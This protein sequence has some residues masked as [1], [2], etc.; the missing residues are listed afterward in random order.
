MAR[1]LSAR[2]MASGRAG[3]SSSPPSRAR[4]GTPA[5]PAGSPSQNSAGFR[6]FRR[7]RR[8]REIRQG[9]RPRLHGAEDR[10]CWTASKPSTNASTP[11]RSGRAARRVEIGDQT[12]VVGDCAE[13]LALHAGAIGR[14]RRHLAALQHRR[15]NTAPM[16][17]AAT[18]ANISPGCSDIALL[19]KRVLKDDGSFF[20][21]IAG[22]S[23]DPWIAADAANAMRDV[24][25]LQNSIVWVKSVSIGDD[26]FGHFKP[27]NSPRY[28]NHLARAR[29]PLHQGRA[30]RRSTGSRSACR[31]RT[32]R[33]SRAGA[34][35]RTAAAAATSGSSPTARSA[36]N[37]SATTIRAPSPSSSPSAASSCTGCLTKPTC[38]QRSDGARSVSRRRLDASCGAATRL[39]R[40][41]H[42]D[43]PVLCGRGRLASSR[44]AD[45]KNEF[46]MRPA[47][48]A[49]LTVS[50]TRSLAD[51]NGDHAAPQRASAT[52]VVRNKSHPS[53]HQSQTV[54]PN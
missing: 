54:P 7:V 19:L 44:A 2:A 38:G 21:N 22:T 29:L 28:L 32:S 27:V 46:W 15:S 24:F 33:T 35:R 20:L 39:P 43:R 4:R 3:R 52:R 18:A 17:M 51:D 25:R 13:A 9:V 42:R 8:A 47:R 45:L 10:A 50:D 6:D 1:K 37:R 34:I 16:T 31:S 14:R 36:R 40:H 49:L 12:I 53:V 30:R 48:V 41:R 26:S 11:S 5:E 23:S